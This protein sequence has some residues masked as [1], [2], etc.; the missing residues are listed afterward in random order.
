MAGSWPRPLAAVLRPGNA[1][2]NTD[3]DHLVVLDRAVTQLPDRWR[4]STMP[5]LVRADGAGYSHTLISA[6]SAQGLVFSSATRSPTPS[7]Q[8]SAPSSNTPGRP[9]ATPTGACVSTPTSSRSQACST[10]AAGRR[11]ARACGPSCAASCRTPVRRWSP[12][13]I[14]DGYRYQAFTTNTRLPQHWPWTLALAQGIPPPAAHPAPGLTPTTTPDQQPHQDHGDTG[15][16][17][18]ALSRPRA[19]QDHDAVLILSPMA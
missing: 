3:S 18:G 1:G 13:Q 10:W 14:R 7:A 5:I 12:C 19:S 16:R 4:E 17:A 9:P 15:P 11:P 6:M 8:R 2:S